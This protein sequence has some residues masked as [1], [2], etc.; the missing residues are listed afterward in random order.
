MPGLPPKLAARLADTRALVAATTLAVRET[1]AEMRPSVLDY[2]GLPAALNQLARQFMQ[3]TSIGVRFSTGELDMQCG[4]DLQMSL[5]YIAQQALENCA[6]HA[7]ASSVQI[8]A[9]CL[10]GQV[11]MTITDNGVGFDPAAL[12][13]SRK[14]SL[15]LLTMTERAKALG[16]AIDIQSRP[17]SGTTVRVEVPLGSTRPAGDEVVAARV[18]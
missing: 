17:S 13:R 7:Q 3:R 2:A 8:D 18:A 14:P 1:A 16:G 15:G 11:V 5:Y 6:K 10:R 9:W 4:H 12:A